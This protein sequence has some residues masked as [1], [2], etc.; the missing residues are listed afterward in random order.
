[1]S[2]KADMAPKNTVSL[3]CRIAMM[4]AMNHVLSP[5][6]ETMITDSDAIKAW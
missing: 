1:M 5:N 6:S 3:E 4:A 2:A